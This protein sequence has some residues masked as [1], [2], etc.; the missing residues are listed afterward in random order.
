MTKIGRA[1]LACVMELLVVKTE[2]M[3]LNVNTYY[4]YLYTRVGFWECM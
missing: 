2:I 4:A 1:Y 3:V